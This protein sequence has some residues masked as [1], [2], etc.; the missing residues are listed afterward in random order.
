MLGVFV[1]AVL[2]GLGAA[3]NFTVVVSSVRL[4]STAYL[5]PGGLDSNPFAVGDASNTYSWGDPANSYAE[6]GLHC[7][8]SSPPTGA[9]QVDLYAG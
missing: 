2:V 7:F 6:L 3:E 5:E 4:I 8:P 9:D 1:L